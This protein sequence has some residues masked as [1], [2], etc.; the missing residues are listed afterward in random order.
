MSNITQAQQ[1]EIFDTFVKGSITIIR[2]GNWRH[3]PGGY[4]DEEM[5]SNVV[6]YQGKTYS[7]VEFRNGDTHEEP[8]VFEVYAEKVVLGHTFWKKVA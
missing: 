4:D 5:R 1:N 6:E 3:M 8:S 2:H 7:I